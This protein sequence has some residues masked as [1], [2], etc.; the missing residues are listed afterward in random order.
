[1]RQMT[2]L[3]Q[4]DLINTLWFHRS[5]LH[6]AACPVRQ[7]GAVGDGK[8]DDTQ[9]FQKALNASYDLGSTLGK[10]ILG[11]YY[12]IYQCPFKLACVYLNKLSFS[13][14]RLKQSC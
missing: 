4:P 12:Y 1:M 10:G 7:F 6:F 14:L 5:V 3:H 13:S 9:A 11:L 2:C 8:Q